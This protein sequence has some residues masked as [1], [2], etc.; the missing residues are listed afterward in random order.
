[1]A[2]ERAGLS[3]APYPHSCAPWHVWSRGEALVSETLGVPLK[4]CQG[5]D[6]ADF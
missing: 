3:L 6:K 2:G 5:W 4:T 1:M